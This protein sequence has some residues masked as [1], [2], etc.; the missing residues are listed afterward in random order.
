MNMASDLFT[1]LV[2]GKAGEGVKT[3][4]GSAAE[5]FSEMGRH[6]FQMDDY[7][8]LI[9]GG[10]NYSLVSSD[11]EPI[12]SHHMR[13]DLI[14]CLDQKS[15]DVHKDHVSDRGLVVLNEG[16]VEG[17][18]AFVPLIKEARKYPKPE[19]RLGLGAFTVLC[20]AMGMPEDDLKR[21][22]EREYPKDKEVNLA[23]GLSIYHATSESVGQRFDPRPG[24]FKG[25]RILTGNE[26]IALGAASA[27]LDVYYAYPMTPSSSILH[28]LAA[29]DRDLG[30]E[31][32]HAESEIAVINMA[33]GSTFAG[34]RAM[35]GTSG[36]GFAL[37]DEAISLAGMVE[38]PILS[39]LSSRPGPSTGVPTYTAQAD[40][41]FALGRGFGEFP[42]IVAS[43]GTV[44]EAFYLASEML[45]L[46][47]RFQTPGILLTEKHL[48]ESAMNVK[49]DVER[50]SYPQPLMHTSGEYRR[51][52]LTDN[53]ISP[54]LFPPS[55]HMIKWNSYEHDEAGITTEDAGTIKKMADKR[56]TKEKALIRHLIGMR[57]VNTYGDG[58]VI[59]T[60]GSTTM[61]VMEA[62]RIS[63]IEAKVLQPVYLRP[64][65][66]WEMKA[67]TKE[68][69]V[70]VEQSCS[71]MF[72][73]LLREKAGI[74]ASHVIRRYDGRPFDPKELSE[75]L[76]EVI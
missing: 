73:R 36:G 56:L 18:G 13:A 25:S 10:H 17:E 8:S 52:T 38:S 23:Y 49:L 45:D 35:I 65:P 61:S 1:F 5:L 75:R 40:L 7:Q 32:V 19:L 22:L 67:F 28:Y 76:K 72:A 47:W 12:W 50:A 33:I 27:G 63:G 2:G 6:V 54:L 48:S 34:A 44:E 62:L 43:P 59:M 58:P 20:A 11:I 15:Y 46:V 9:R 41:D 64:F 30:V 68:R 3:A 42:Q 14:V 57:T 51:Y 29:H 24:T 26:A 53:G 37:M 71:G 69:P 70:V 60:Y 4:A 16:A 55:P 74:T 31:V 21:I 39:I 66:V